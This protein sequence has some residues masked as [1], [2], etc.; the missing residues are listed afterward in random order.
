ML[1]KEFTHTEKHISDQVEGSAAG[2]LEPLGTGGQPACLAR[3]SAKE[4]V[5]ALADDQVL[6][7]LS[8]TVKNNPLSPITSL[9]H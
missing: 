6:S 9:L 2:H 7:A 3:M 8:P 5:I 1:R 4:Q